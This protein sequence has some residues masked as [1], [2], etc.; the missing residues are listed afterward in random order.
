MRLLMIRHGQSEADILKVHEG[1]ANFSLTQLGMAQAEI[2]AEYVTKEFDISKIYSSTLKRAIE[3]AAYIDAAAKAQLI[4]KDDLMEFNNGLLAGLPFDEAERRYPR[5]DNRKPHMNEYGMESELEFRFRAERVLS[6]ILYETNP[7]ETIAI[8]S[9]GGMINQMIK[10][11]LGLQIDKNPIF[12]TGDTGIHLLMLK[13]NMR[14]VEFLNFIPY[15]L[16]NK[17]I[18]PI[19]RI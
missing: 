9:H 8:V 17:G 14:Y 10:S 3:T 12:F 15:K 13:N 6:G 18:E 2:M 19:W 7:E 4:L 1:R 5:N 11:F 16:S